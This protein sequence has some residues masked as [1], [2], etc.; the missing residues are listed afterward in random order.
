MYGT[1]LKI[2]PKFGLGPSRFG[3][4]RVVIMQFAI[5]RSPRMRNADARTPQANPVFPWKSWLCIIGW[6]IPPNDE[7]VRTIPIARALRFFQ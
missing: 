7:P 4:S 5:T 6:M 3:G 2:A 1:S